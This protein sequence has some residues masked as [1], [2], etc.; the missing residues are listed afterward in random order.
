MGIKSYTAAITAALALGLFFA[1][2]VSIAIDAIIH[3]V[4]SLDRP[5]SAISASFPLQ[6]VNLA[7][8]RKNNRMHS[9]RTTMQ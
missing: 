4:A 5:P 7:H 2:P 6:W 8:S 9:I 3:R 1:P